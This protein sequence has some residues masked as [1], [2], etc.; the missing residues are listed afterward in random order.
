MIT[1]IKIELSDEQRK[2]LN[3]VLTGK[4]GLATRKTIILWAQ[5][6]LAD[7]LERPNGGKTQLRNMVCPK[8][9]KPIAIDVPVGAPSDKAKRPERFTAAAKKTQ[10]SIEQLR[11]S[12]AEL[13]TSLEVG[14]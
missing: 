6:T 12:L 8:C 5:R 1:T 13:A 11:A 10:G 7:K 14:S 2:A 3:V 4:S 9:H